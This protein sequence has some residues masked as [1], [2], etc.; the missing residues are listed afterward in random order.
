MDKKKEKFLKQFG[1]IKDLP[2]LPVIVAKVNQ[3]LDDPYTTIDSL[4][5]VI[6]KDQAI[7]FKMLRLVNSAFFGFREKIASTSEAAIILGFDAIRNIVIS[8]STFKTLNRIASQ[9]SCDIF[10]AES[11]WNH[12]VGVAVLSKYLADKSRIGDPE[13]C[14]VAGLLHDMGK[15]IMAYYF[16]D[17]FKKILDLSKKEEILYREAEEKTFPA[18]HHETGYFIAKKWNLPSHLSSTIYSHHSIQVGASTYEDSLIV[19]TADGII[20]SY[21]VDF[22]NNNTRPGKLVYQYFDK[23]TQK[24][25]KLWIE[26]SAKWFPEVNELIGD[27]RKLFQEI[28]NG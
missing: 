24:R 20:N 9:R 22:L 8:L 3:M 18:S 13:K 5:N 14:F 15:L 1:S 19:N 26:S 27:A 16:I 2:S 10:K 11:F 23:N 6:E 4:S 28:E 12:S 25:M 21:T 17:D 7:V